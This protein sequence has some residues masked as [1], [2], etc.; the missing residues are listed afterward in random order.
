MP[1]LEDKVTHAVTDLLLTPIKGN[2][3]I[4]VLCRVSF[5][6][7]FQYMASKHANSKA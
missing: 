3:A 6:I 7:F 4:T 1:K 2:S 5:S